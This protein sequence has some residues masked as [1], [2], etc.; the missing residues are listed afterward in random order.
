M[1]RFHVLL[2]AALFSFSALIAFAQ[3][4]T[5]CNAVARAANYWMPQRIVKQSPGTTGGTTSVACGP[6][7]DVAAGS[8]APTKVNSRPRIESRRGRVRIENNTVVTDTGV[9]L[10]ATH[11][12]ANQQ[13]DLAWLRRMRDAYGLNAMRLDVRITTRPTNA[14]YADSTAYLKPDLQKVFSEVDKVI[15]LTEKAGMYL[16]ITNFSSCCGSYNLKLNQIFWDK[17]APRYKD[18]K[19]VLYEVQNEPVIGAEYT[20]TAISFQKTM[21]D[22]I[23]QRA[24]QTHI[25][26]WSSMYGA[27]A[28]LF[29][30]VRRASGIS[31]SNASV[32]LHTY[33]HNRDDPNWANT[34]KL[35]NSYPV[36]ITEFSK[37]PD[38]PAKVDT[39]KVWEYAERSKLSWAYLD[40]RRTDSGYG[41]HGDGVYNVCDWHFIWAAPAE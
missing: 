34:E 39:G 8:C 9:I 19:H 38:K 41:N 5:L 18:R 31:Y 26:L 22:Y 10:R 23:R 32:G 29:D 21:Y 4:G 36:I 16:I 25:I 33:W 20:S 7:G 2:A 35:R 30:T 40:L 12:N 37:S 28:S 13:K 3:S 1:S 24:P 27:K 17:A 6:R 15:N 11:M 14:H